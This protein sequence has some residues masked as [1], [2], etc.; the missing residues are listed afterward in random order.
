[1]QPVTSVSR[2]IFSSTGPASPLARIAQVSEVLVSVSTDSM[3][4]ETCTAS[5]SS[6]SSVAA[7]NAA[8]VKMYASI[9]AMFGSIIPEPFATQV[10]VALPALSDNAFA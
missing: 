2:N 10:I 3:L 5:R 7:S 9:V 1:M 8:S 6:R 4:N